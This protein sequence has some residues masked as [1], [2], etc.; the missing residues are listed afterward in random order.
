MNRKPNRIAV[1][2]FAKLAISGWSMGWSMGSAH[3]IGQNRVGRYKLTKRRQIEFE[4]DLS[5][6]KKERQAS[7]MSNA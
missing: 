6:W 7:M 3:D 5:V 1:A 2:L 4:N